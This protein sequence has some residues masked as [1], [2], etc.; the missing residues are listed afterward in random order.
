MLSKL[1]QQLFVRHK[2]QKILL[3][4]YKEFFKTKI[5]HLQNYI[6]SNLLKNVVE[7]YKIDLSIAYWYNSA[8]KN[9]YHKNMVGVLFGTPG[10][11]EE[12]INA[13]WSHRRG[14]EIFNYFLNL[15]KNIK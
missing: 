5:K 1:V 14:Y 11:P 3:V 4:A 15:S 9:V 2:K 7:K 6:L 12:Y 8:G 13:V 10:K